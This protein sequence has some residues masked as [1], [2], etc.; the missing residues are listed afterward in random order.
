M[1]IIV[2]DYA[3]KLQ[4]Y[5]V[6]WSYRAGERTEQDTKIIPK[7]FVAKPTQGGVEPPPV[8]GHLSDGEP[9]VKPTQ[10]RS[11]FVLGK[12]GVLKKSKKK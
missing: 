3:P 1:T 12:G 2:Y 5:I 10:Q 4:N 8:T 9:I 6:G 11:V 7:P